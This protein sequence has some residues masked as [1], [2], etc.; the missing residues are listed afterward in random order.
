MLKTDSLTFYFN[1]WWRLHIRFDPAEHLNHCT[2]YLQLMISKCTTILSSS[3]L[4]ML[5]LLIVNLFVCSLYY[6]DVLHVQR[7]LNEHTN[8]SCS[9]YSVLNECLSDTENILYECMWRFLYKDV[10]VVW[11]CLCESVQISMYVCICLPKT[12]LF[13]SVNAFDFGSFFMYFQFNSASFS[14][15]LCKDSLC[16]RRSVLC[17]WFLSVFFSIL[18]F[19][20]VYELSSTHS[21]GRISLFFLCRSPNW[22]VNC[23]Q[24]IRWWRLRQAKTIQHCY[25]YW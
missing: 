2:H 15:A 1:P 11:V 24:V 21:A 23:K 13:H 4:P 9:F 25:R 3:S 10:G 5:A 20:W 17:C 19:L 7:I 8:E 16:N 22:Q 6:L 12:N 18:L 14:P